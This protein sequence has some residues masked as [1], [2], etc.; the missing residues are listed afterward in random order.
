M[1][2]RL[3]STKI[4]TKTSKKGKLETILGSD[5]GDL[6]LMLYFAK[7]GSEQSNRLTKLLQ[8]FREEVLVKKGFPVEIMLVSMDSDIKEMLEHYV[9]E[10]GQW[11][12]I[13]YDAVAR[14]DLGR[15]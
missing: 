13:E 10:Q 14:R 3:A 2:A 1:S 5:L 4:W 15:L 8:D 7:K 11:L 12:A 9:N 6:T